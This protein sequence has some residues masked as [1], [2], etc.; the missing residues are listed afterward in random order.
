MMPVKIQKNCFLSEIENCHE[1]ICLSA[2]V[3]DDFLF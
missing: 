2:G 3:T 1:K